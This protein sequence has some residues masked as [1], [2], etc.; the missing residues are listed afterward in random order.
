MQDNL[1]EAFN[2]GIDAATDAEMIAFVN[3]F[4]HHLEKSVMPTLCYTLPKFNYIRYHFDIASSFN[5]YAK[6][7]SQVVLN[8][9]RTITYHALKLSFELVTL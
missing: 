2:I 9:V 7:L 8:W 3:G 1:I 4:E 5:T 6:G